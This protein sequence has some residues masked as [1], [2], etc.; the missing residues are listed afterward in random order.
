LTSSRPGEFYQRVVVAQKAGFTIAHAEITGPG[1]S[2]DLVKR[3]ALRF[4]QSAGGMIEKGEIW[5]YEQELREA[6]SLK[7]AKG[8]SGGPVVLRV[9]PAHVRNQRLK[10]D[11]SEHIE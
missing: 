4:A 9:Q 10:T 1:A 2:K 3:G 11:S 8:K 6:N 5:F 7:L